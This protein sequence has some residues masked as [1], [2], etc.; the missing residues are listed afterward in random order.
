M[1]SLLSDST[2][3]KL[4]C[5]KST[6]GGT[7]LREHWNEE[8][9]LR[10]RSLIEKNKYDVVVLQDH[11]LRAIEYPDSLIEY[12]KKFCNLIL[13]RGATPILYTTW[14]RKAKPETQETINKVYGEIAKSCGASNVWVGSY[15]KKYLQ[16]DPNA[17]LYAKDG[18]HPS[19]LGSFIAAVAFV[20][21][22]TGQ[23]PKGI[24]S[25][26]NY[27]DKDGETFRILQVSQEEIKITKSVI[28]GN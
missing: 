24:P 21:K 28:E 11:S 15:W 5:T 9:S 27:F 19:Y 22:I 1:V 2:D 8:K 4:L 18:S 7:N 20:K 3:T 13:S 14:S 12:G 17:E 26:F 16:L 23:M 10:S 6:V 25:V